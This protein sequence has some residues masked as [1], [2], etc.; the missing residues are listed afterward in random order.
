MQ[1][2]SKS[3]LNIG[4]TQPQIAIAENSENLL[5]GIVGGILAAGIGAIIWALIT[6]WTKFQIGWMAVGL[7]LLV[8]FAIRFLGKGESIKFGII[9][10]ILALLGCLAGN[11]LTTCIWASREYDVSIFKIISVVDFQLI[12]DILKETFSPIDLIFYAIAIYEGYKF[13]F[14]KVINT[15]NTIS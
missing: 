12:V 1:D 3:Q 13:S 5:F 9:G 2:P 8:G 15:K 14:K 6:Y 10:A 11:V 4:N 7:G